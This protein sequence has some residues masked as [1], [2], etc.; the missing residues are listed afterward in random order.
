MEVDAVVWVAAIVVGYAL[1]SRRTSA[2][3]LSGPMVFV[4]GGY[5]LGDDGLGLLELRVGGE[6]VVLLAEVTLAVLLFSDAARADPMTLTKEYTLPAR[7]LGIGL[8]LTIALGTIVTALLLTDLDLAEAALVAAILAPTDAALGQP[9]VTDPSVPAR[10][11]ETL[12]VESGLNDG[13]VV[14][15]VTVLIAF[16][17][18]GDGGGAT[19]WVRLAAEQ[20]GIGTAVGLGVALVAGTAVLRAIRAGWV[21]EAY[22][23]LAFLAM[24]IGAWSLAST[25]DGN[26]F[27]AAFVAGLTLAVTTDGEGEEHVL[28]AEDVGQLLALVAFVLFGA[29]FVGPALGELTVPVLVC[30]VGTLT[31][32]RMLP[33]A[34]SLTGTGLRRPTVAFIGWFGPRGLASLLFGLLLVTEAEIEA[35]D[36]LFTVITTV[37]LAS[38]ILHGMTA[39]PLARRYGR[40]YASMDDED[41]V[42]DAET[43]GPIRPRWYRPFRSS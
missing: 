12:N 3:P 43:M 15:V 17:E 27:I 23:Q 42:E 30:A 31:M 28:V 14:P 26:G 33:V 11:R 13:L 39:G 24:A 37:V 36:D 20:I 16:T 25:L 4:A 18:R 21:E 1:V 38:I 22:A 34:V 10:V 6:E 2:W 32:G 35:G 5:A 41:M 9:V 7:L 40:W 8:P 29:L 19:D